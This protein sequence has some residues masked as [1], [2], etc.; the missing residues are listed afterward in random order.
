MGT[1]DSFSKNPTHVLVH[2]TVDFDDLSACC[3]RGSAGA[4]QNCSEWVWVWDLSY[5]PEFVGSLW[6]ACSV[7]QGASMWPALP[8]PQSPLSQR[9]LRNPATRVKGVRPYFDGDSQR[10]VSDGAQGRVQSPLRQMVLRDLLGNLLG[11]DNRE[12]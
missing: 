4:S 12:E 3:L 8:S 10:H 5:R 7:G 9:E 11:R 2:K 1:Y 6:G